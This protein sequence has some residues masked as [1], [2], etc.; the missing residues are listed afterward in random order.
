MEVSF[1][2]DVGGKTLT[3]ETGKLAKQA[4]G[5]VLVRY[6]ETL[7]LVTVPVIQTRKP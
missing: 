7:V 4:G 6:G 3:V 1:M 2:G 5:A